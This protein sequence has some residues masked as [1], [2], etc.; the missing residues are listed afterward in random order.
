MMV[1]PVA[2][3][4][5]YVNSIHSLDVHYQWKLLDPQKN[6]MFLRHRPRH[7][8]YLP[9]SRIK[10]F[11]AFPVFALKNSLYIINCQFNLAISCRNFVCFLVLFVD[12]FCTHW[13]LHILECKHFWKFLGFIVFISKSIKKIKIKNC[14]LHFSKN[15]S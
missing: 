12:F 1:S 11:I 13:L 5:R 9:E 2:A 6:Y 3:A 8:Q 10:N 14:P 4:L 7:L 15:S